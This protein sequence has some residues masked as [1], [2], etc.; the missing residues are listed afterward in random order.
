MTITMN[1]GDSE[2]I[3]FTVKDAQGEPI[4]FTLDEIYFS[5]KKTANDRN[6][7]FQ[8]RKSDGEI[9]DDGE[10]G[11]T[12]TILPEDTDKLGFGKYVFDIEVISTAVTPAIKKSFVGELILNPEVTHIYNE[13]V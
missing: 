4:E 2:N 5:V 12:F 11:Y 13:E 9:V 7:L 1:R 3:S 10:G 6:V 8:K